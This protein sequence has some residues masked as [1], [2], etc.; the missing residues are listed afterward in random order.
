MRFVICEHSS[1]QPGDKAIPQNKDN[2][3]KEIEIRDGE[4]DPGDIGALMS[5]SPEPT[6]CITL[7]SVGLCEPI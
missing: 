6:P 3:E 2:L 4:K 7:L 1:S 5:F